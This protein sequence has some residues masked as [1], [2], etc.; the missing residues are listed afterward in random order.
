MYQNPPDYDKRKLL[1]AVAHGSIFLSVAVLSIGIPIAILFISDDS[2]V[3]ANAK[4]AINFHFN[5]WFWSIIIGILTFITFGLLGFV[6]IPIGFLLHWGLSIW[7]IAHAL[8]NPDT[9]FRYPF[10]VRPL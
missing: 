10:I 4:E 3:K 9:P 2:V 6:L 1:S 8:S 7:A 5:V